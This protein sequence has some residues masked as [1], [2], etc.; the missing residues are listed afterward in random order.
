MA[1]CMKW[2]LHQMHAAFQPKTL[3]CLKTNQLDKH[4]K[5]R[6]GSEKRLIKS[7]LDDKCK[8]SA[9]DNLLQQ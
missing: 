3:Y 1:S 5:N 7:P 8:F 9:S 2:T 4:L 6:V